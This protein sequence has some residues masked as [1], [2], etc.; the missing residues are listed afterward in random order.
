MPLA[1]VCEEERDSGS[2]RIILM[3]SLLESGMS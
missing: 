2:T 3:L 1:T